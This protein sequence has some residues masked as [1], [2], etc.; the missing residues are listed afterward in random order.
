M[1]LS[2]HLLPGHPKAGLRV[3]TEGPKLSLV[4]IYQLVHTYSLPSQGPNP[5]L[6]L[7]LPGLSPVVLSLL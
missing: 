4:W 3:A 5:P 7:S 1:D 6:T 2:H